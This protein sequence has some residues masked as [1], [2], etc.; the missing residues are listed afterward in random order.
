[1]LHVN[2]ATLN[3]IGDDA[4]RMDTHLYKV[5]QEWLQTGK[6]KTWKTL[7]E[8]LRNRTVARPDVGKKTWFYF[9]YVFFFKVSS[10]PLTFLM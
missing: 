1:M 2:I 3:A 4:N 8:A 6:D 9:L 7:S 10:I 5:L